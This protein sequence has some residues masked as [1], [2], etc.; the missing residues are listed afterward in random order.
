MLT[1]IVYNFLIDHQ[2]T[3]LIQE[4]III[5]LDPRFNF[6]NGDDDFAQFFEETSK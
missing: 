1:N 3:D 2:Q 5:S 4:D 6:K